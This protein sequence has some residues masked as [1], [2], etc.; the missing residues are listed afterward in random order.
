[1]WNDGSKKKQP[2]KYWK[3]SPAEVIAGM[4]YDWRDLKLSGYSD[5]QIQSVID[6]EY[7]LQ[8]LF[9]IKPEDKPQP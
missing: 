1:M 8:D 7:T 5:K 2:P 9:K 4:D 3:R 6:G